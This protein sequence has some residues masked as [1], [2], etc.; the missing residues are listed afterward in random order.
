VLLNL[1][2]FASLVAGRFMSPLFTAVS[3]FVHPYHVLPSPCSAQI[4]TIPP[5]LVRSPLLVLDVNCC[6]WFP[7]ICA[8]F[9]WKAYLV[10][11]PACFILASFGHFFLVILGRLIWLSKKTNKDRRKGTVQN[12]KKGK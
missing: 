4:R 3:S 2:A 12:Q 8:W 11:P 10:R 7:A 1:R 9:V 5:N 6:C